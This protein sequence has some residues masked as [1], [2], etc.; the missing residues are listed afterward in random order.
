TNS[1]GIAAN[2]IT[3][4]QNAQ[5]KNNTTVKVLLYSHSTTQLVYSKDF[6]A[7]AQQIKIDTSKLPNGIYYLN[8]IANGEKI[9]QQ[10]IV[11]NH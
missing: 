3:G 9:K 7:S 2:A 1:N 6:P 8:I 10:T 5:A 11:V 4:E